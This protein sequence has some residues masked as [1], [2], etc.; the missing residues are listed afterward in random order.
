MERCVGAV[1]AFKPRRS[2]GSYTLSA[3]A[4]SLHAG[5]RESSVSDPQNRRVRRQLGQPCGRERA[6]LLF[7]GER[8][9]LESDSSN[10]LRGQS[11]LL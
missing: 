1:R 10:G 8:I 4:K 9:L 5:N 7:F 6:P 3:A 11:R 2:L